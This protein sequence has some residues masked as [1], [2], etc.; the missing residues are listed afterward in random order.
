MLHTSLH[1][2]VVV[3]YNRS[4]S[5]YQLIT[6]FPFF[7]LFET[8]CNTFWTNMKM[9]NHE[10]KPKNKTEVFDLLEVTTES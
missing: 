7:D 10:K 6:Y 1:T 2:I 9:G 3:F 5:Q 8:T 4:Y